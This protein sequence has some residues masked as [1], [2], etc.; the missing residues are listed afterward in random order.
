[1]GYARRLAGRLVAAAALGAGLGVAFAV[2]SGHVVAQS[3]GVPLESGVA[4]IHLRTTEAE[5]SAI[6][7][8]VA[9]T[10]AILIRLFWAGKRQTLR[11][12]AIG[13]LGAMSV[14]AAELVVRMF[15][16]L[17]SG[18]VDRDQPLSDLLIEAWIRGITVPIIAAAAGGLIGAALWFDADRRRGPVRWTL[19]GMAL[20][21]VL[22][23]V[24][25]GEEDA[26]GISQ[27]AKVAW[28]AAVA[29]MAL[30][31]LRVGLQLAL[32]S[33]R[34]EAERPAWS[35][36]TYC[37]NTVP[38]N[39]FC[40]SCGVATAGRTPSHVQA[41]GRLLTTWVG[42]VAVLALA[43]VGVSAQTSKP[44]ER[45]L[46]PPNCGRPPMGQPMAVNPVFTAADGGFA[47]SY[48]SPG[49][50][51]SVTTDDTGVTAQFL[52]GDGGVM[53]LFG[54]P[55]HG[56]SARDIATDLAQDAYPDSRVAYELPNTLVGY[57]PGYGMALDDWPD[58]SNVVNSRTR[59]L[60]MV[61]VKDDLALIAAAAGP[62]HVLGSD[63]GPPTGVSLE[64]AQ[65][66]GKYVNS[67]RWRGDPVR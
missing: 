6:A 22:A 10:P 53:R 41:T 29:L 44:D 50:A 23:H 67:F 17:S 8:L 25:L 64:L 59:I 63:S 19:L 31:L 54:Q 18:L 61:A 62:Y 35:A 12:F 7:A 66:M 37:G 32:L 16:Q 48:P 38:D 60:V 13:A 43:L 52:G 3:Y 20:V 2:V 39:A 55:A 14:A 5:V 33:E 9:L 57:Q 11:G 65:D 26:A 28:H 58:G 21:S 15:A 27:W 46:C 51:Y 49:A 47:V 40:T 36:C 1:M 24:L 34:S 30:V 4:A 45:Y 56:R 42:V